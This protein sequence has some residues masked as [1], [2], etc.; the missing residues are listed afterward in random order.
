MAE[1]RMGLIYHNRGRATIQP[2]LRAPEKIRKC[3]NDQPGVL[4]QEKLLHLEH[5]E[6]RPRYRILQGIEQLPSAAFHGVVPDCF[7]DISIL[8][9]HTEMAERSVPLL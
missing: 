4:S 3:R 5:G 2:P 7:L 6:T 9:L 1:R 8:Q